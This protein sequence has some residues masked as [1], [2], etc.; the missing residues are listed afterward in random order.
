VPSADVM[1]HASHMHLL[2][3]GLLHA[4]KTQ[5]AGESGRCQVTCPLVS[6]SC[7]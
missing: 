4:G 2:G 6:V 3:L 1:K 5:L 7:Q